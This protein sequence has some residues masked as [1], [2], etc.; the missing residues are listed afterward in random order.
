[1]I[2]KRFG[3]L[4]VTKYSGY[5]NKNLMVEATCD[6]GNTW[7]GVAY[8]LRRGRTKS[9]GC[10]KT[11]S[12]IN[13]RFGKLIITKIIGKN[14]YKIPIIEAKCDCGGLWS[15]V[16]SHL[17]NGKTKSCGC[18]GNGRYNWMGGTTRTKSGYILKY[19]KGHPRATKKGSY[20]F[21][22]ILVMEGFLGRYVTKDESIHH[23]NGIKDD[24]RIE[25]L[26]LRTKN[27]GAGI[28]SEDAIKHAICIL[29]KYAPHRLIE[30]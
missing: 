2:G 10:A 3:K 6:C 21:E 4:I 11:R 28:S 30:E 7:R 19:C 24:N 9:C 15:G 20:V 5:K 18:L 16:Y 27:H 1:M 8:L 22:H 23:K 17:K 29:K 14:K 25:N 13:K 12:L 26:E